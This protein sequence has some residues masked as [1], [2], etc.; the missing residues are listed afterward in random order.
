MYAVLVFVLFCFCDGVW[1][2]HIFR[3]SNQ[4]TYPETAMSH[5]CCSLFWDN[6]ALFSLGFDIAFICGMPGILELFMAGLWMYQGLSFIRTL[7]LTTR[8]F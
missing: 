2:Y 3:K 6:S 1:Y 5:G 4:R 8:P 7:I